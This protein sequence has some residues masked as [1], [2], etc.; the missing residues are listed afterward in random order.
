MTTEKVKT[1][2]ERFDSLFQELTGIAVSAAESKGGCFL[3]IPPEVDLGSKPR[4]KRI[5]IGELA[6]PG[7]WHNHVVDNQYTGWYIRRPAK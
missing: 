3:F 5:M 2:R 4:G 1:R 6:G 7:G